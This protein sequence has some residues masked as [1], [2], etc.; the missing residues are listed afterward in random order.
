MAFSRRP[1]RFYGALVGDCLRTHGTFTALPLRASSC[2]R[3]RTACALRV[4]G[5]PTAM[6]AF[7]LHSEEVEIT[8]RVLIPQLRQYP[9]IP[10]INHAL[11]VGLST[12]MIEPKAY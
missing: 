10:V 12:A 8:D 6:T 2:H 11:A 9:M 5:A 1:W 4:H 3:A 7:C